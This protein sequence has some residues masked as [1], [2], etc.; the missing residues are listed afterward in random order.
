MDILNTHLAES[1]QTSRHH[2][3]TYDKTNADKIT[4]IKIT[5]I[6][7]FLDH[8]A[9]ISVDDPFPGQREKTF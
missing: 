3:V 4:L 5:I 2:V 1:V 7:D 9:H 6:Y 8:T